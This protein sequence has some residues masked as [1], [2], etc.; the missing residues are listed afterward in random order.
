MQN[1]VLLLFVLMSGH[2]KLDYR[3]VF[4]KRLEILPS[5]PKVQQITLDLMESH[6]SSP[7]LRKVLPCAK[8]YGCVL[9]DERS[10]EKDEINLI[11]Y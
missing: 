11:Q 3:K 5:T 1:K 8:L 7:I 10:L 9:L 2:K 6:L 4:E